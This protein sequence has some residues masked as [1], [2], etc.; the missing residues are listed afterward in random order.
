M[1]EPRFREF[2]GWDLLVA[3][4]AYWYL[5]SDGRPQNLKLFH[6]CHS[7]CI[8]AKAAV[9]SVKK[10]EEQRLADLGDE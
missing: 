1:Q 8:S 10:G 7:S 6:C 2:C 9:E 5:V 3:N 4:S